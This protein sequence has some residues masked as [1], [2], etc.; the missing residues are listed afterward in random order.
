MRRL[1]QDFRKCSRQTRLRPTGRPHGISLT[2]RSGVLTG[3]VAALALLLFAAPA[4]AVGRCGNH[5][6][7]D[8][9]LGPDERAGLLLAELTLDEKVSLMAGDDASTGLNQAEPVERRNTGESQGVPRLELP[10]VF[11]SDGPVGTR[12]GKATG[13][14]ASIGLAA[15]WD[16][17][18]AERYGGVVGNEVRN[19]GNDVVHAPTVNIMRTPLGGRTFEGYGEDPWLTSR[20]GV[21]WSKGAQAEG[22]VANVKHYA[23]NNQEPDRFITNAVVDPRTLREIYL[24]AFEANVKEANAGSVMCSYNRVNGQFACEN[25]ELLEEILRDE[26]GFKGYVLTDYGFAQKSTANSANNGLELEMPVGGWYG[27]TSLNLAV[28]SGQVAPSTVDLHVRRILRTMFAYGMF[29]RDAYRYDDNAIDQQGH[30]AVAR[31]VEESAIT[32]LRNDG[33]ALPIDLSRTKSIALIGS[34]ANEYKRGGG[35]SSVDPFYSVTPR[36]GI[37]KRVGNAAQVSFDD[38]SQPARAAAAARSA[39]VAIVFASDSQTEFVDKPCLT[40][41]CGNPAKGDQDSLIRTVAQANP[42]TIVVLQT[43]GPVLTPWADQV[44]AIVEA[45]YPGAEGGN[46]LARVLFGDVDPGGRLPATF[47]ARE[48]DLPTSGRPERYPGVAENAEYS[49]GVFIGYRHFDQNKIAPRFPFGFGLSYARWQYDDLRIAPARGGRVA[50]RVSAT[51]R[52]V[53]DRPGTEVAQLYVGL[54]SPGATVPQPP[55]ALKAFAKVSLGPGQA[56]R[57]S[58]DLDER[59]LS[60]WNEAAKDWSIAPGCYTVEVARS[61]RDPQLTG[62]LTVGGSRGGCTQGAVALPRGSACSASAPRSSISGAVRATRRRVSLRGRT[63]DLACRGNSQRGRVRSVDVAV[64]QRAGR[65]CRW[66]G[67]GGRLARRATSCATPAFA[68]RG[69]LGRL[70][71]GKVPWT[72]R[73]PARGLPRGNYVVV[74]RAIDT[75]GAVERRLGRFNRRSFRIR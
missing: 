35:S 9:T 75:G 68:R 30:G 31:E 51:V 4:S 21:A 5:P 41:Q 20:I 67:R 29:D 10:T 22:V 33:G 6:W 34:D 39:D 54:P 8:T 28:A 14:P 42:N 69:R 36:A 55:R 38:G 27:R 37:E 49:E 17:A 13:M 53:S 58:F 65:R 66:L 24:P 43:G 32:L 18:L 48:E 26:W 52:N 74:A 2:V 40:L 47:P 62:A 12:Q 50:A 59:S 71:A 60:Y 15:T 45:W 72:A 46:A 56:K 1:F 70:R 57:V 63:V 64:G 19:K 7:C 3:A 16:T 11:Y 61:S 73:V 44:R 25:R 23:A